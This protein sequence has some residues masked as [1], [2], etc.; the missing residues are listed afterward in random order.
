MRTKSIFLV[1]IIVVV[2][3]AFAVPAVTVSAVSYNCSSQV[4]I[5][6]D[7]CKALVGLY[8]STV[9]SYNWY[10]DTNWLATCSVLLVGGKYTPHRGLSPIL[11]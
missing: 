1:C 6:Q 11:I 8:N 3:L 4:Q 2:F 7:E 9:K 5:P 10:N